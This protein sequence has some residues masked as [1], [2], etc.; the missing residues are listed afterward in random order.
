MPVLRVFPHSLGR[1]TGLSLVELMVGMAIGLLIVALLG[2]I[3]SG[4]RQ[5]YQQQDNLARVQENG[6]AALD[7]ISQDIRSAG[8][9][10]CVG[11]RIPEPINTLNNAADYLY[12]FNTPVEGHQATG[13]NTWSPA[14]DATVTPVLTGTDILTLRGAYGNGTTVTQHPG[15]TPP[16]SADLKV[17]DVSNIAEG[18][19]LLV[20][21]CQNAAVFQVTNLNAG[22]N[23]VHNTGAIAGIV[24]GNASKGL[25]KE[26]VG[27]EVLRASSKTYYIRLNDANR[28]SLY[29]MTNGVAEELVENVESMQLTYGVDTTGDQAVDAYQT[30]DAV[31]DWDQVILVRVQL[32]L[33]SPE[34]G[35]VNTAQGYAFNGANVAP[36]GNLVGGAIGDPDDRRLRLVFTA[37]IGL[38]NRLP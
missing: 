16:G 10:G 23:V 20:S 31:L 4:S 28:P 29:R 18:D 6:R 33:A 24:P 1:Q 14:K 25:G 34:T 35:A 38:R 5:S 19:I 12:R 36:D 22:S 2:Y 13:A 27:G 11:R 32:L 30:A 37:N 9:W 3:Y 26:Y 17:N 21:D 8:Y 7:F 15:G